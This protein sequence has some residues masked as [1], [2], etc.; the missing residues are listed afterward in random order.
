MIKKVYIFCEQVLSLPKIKNSDVK[1]ISIDKKDSF[2][3]TIYSF[4]KIIIIAYIM[5]EI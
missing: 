2:D 4:S 1:E 3:A 5:L